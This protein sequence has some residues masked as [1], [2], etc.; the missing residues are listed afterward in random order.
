MP[1]GAFVMANSIINEIEKYKRLFLDSHNNYIEQYN[2][3]GY[4]LN[5]KFWH[6]KKNN[7]CYIYIIAEIYK[8]GKMGKN[9]KIILFNKFLSVLNSKVSFNNTMSLDKT[10]IVLQKK[11]KNHNLF[12]NK[13]IIFLLKV[14]LYYK[15]PSVFKKYYKDTITPIILIVFLI[16]MI[17]MA[18]LEAKAT[19]D[20]KYNLFGIGN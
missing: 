19:I 18:I 13:F 5:F 15:K 6:E 17:F 11:A 4:I 1:K 20:W 9:E 2:C 12:N 3:Y 10:L 8:K 14:V 16:F 7:I